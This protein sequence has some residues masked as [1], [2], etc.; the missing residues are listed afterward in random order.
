MS[1]V[2]KLFVTISLIGDESAL[3]ARFAV[4]FA[5][6]DKR[7]K[8]NGI[9][10]PSVCPQSGNPLVTVMSPQTDGLRWFMRPSRNNTALVLVDVQKG[11]HDPVWGKRNNPGAEG[12]IK[13]LLR[14]FRD[15]S[16]PIVHVQ[17]VSTD[18]KSPLRQ[19]QVGVEFMDGIQP[20]FKEPVFQ[21]SVNS[22]FIGTGLEKYLRNQKIQFL[23]MVGFTSDHCVSTSTR[24]AANLGFSVNVISDATV[25]FQRKLAGKIFSPDI[26]HE[27]SLAS[28]S[29]EFATIRSIN[30][31]ITSLISSFSKN[32]QDH[33]TEIEAS[34]D[35]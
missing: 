2:L 26:V 35:L 31:E 9:F 12:N 10:S 25:T 22:A 28:L 1:V 24:M 21:K 23:T 32:P 5:K 16:A 20:Q 11:F 30:S 8:F 19:N 14:F 34:Y 7:G 15:A 13:L 27:V 33:S 17:H 4:Q 29:K 3:S 6:Q 18:T